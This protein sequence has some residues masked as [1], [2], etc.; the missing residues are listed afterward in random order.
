MIVSASVA[1]GGMPALIADVGPRR[2]ADLP[3]RRTITQPRAARSL[4]GRLRR[5]ES[6]VG[7]ASMSRQSMAPLVRDSS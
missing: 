2:G 6:L 5:D 7:R 1:Q 4:P 3:S